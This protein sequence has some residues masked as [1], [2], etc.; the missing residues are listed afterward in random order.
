M[1]G[2]GTPSTPWRTAIEHDIHERETIES[3]LKEAHARAEQATQAKSMFPRQHEPR[4]PHPAQ[5]GDRHGRTDSPQPC[6]RPAS[7]TTPR[8][9]GLAGRSPLDTV[10]DILDFSKIRSGR[11]ELE[12][13][14]SALRRWSRTPTCWLSGRPEKG[15]S[16]SSRRARSG[17]LP[18]RS[19]AGDPLRIGQVLGNLLSNAVG[20]HPSGHVSLGWMDRLRKMGA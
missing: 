2:C 19:P 1:Q 13:V 11:L 6:C 17:S 15:S 14:S 20:A 3:A 10:N 8:R 9:S 12:S 4:D 7:A 18:R 16:Y 5:R